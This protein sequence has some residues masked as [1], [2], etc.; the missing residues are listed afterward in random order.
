M[1]VITNPI[2]FKDSLILNVAGTKLIYPVGSGYREV[3]NVKQNVL[4][5]GSV[6]VIVDCKNE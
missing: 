5:C 2:A 3:V 4:E 1:L 6:V